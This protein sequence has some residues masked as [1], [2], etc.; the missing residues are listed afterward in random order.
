MKMDDIKLISLNVRGL[1]NREKRMSIYHYMRNKRADIIYLQETHSTERTYFTWKTEWNSDMICAQGTRGVAILFSKKINCTKE[2]IY[3]HPYGRLL[4]VKFTIGEKC[5]LLANVYNYNIDDTEVFVTL[6]DQ[7]M[8][9]KDVDYF[10]LAGDFNLALDPTV[11]RY[12]GG[13]LNIHTT[14]YL[15]QLMEDFELID[16]WRNRHPNDV[17][18]SWERS[19]PKYTASRLDYI[20]CSETFNNIVHNVEYKHAIR[21]DHKAIVLNLQINQ[22]KRGSGLW[23][24][25]NMMLNDPQFRIFIKQ[26][27]SKA[28][29]KYQYCSPVDKWELIKVCIITSAQKYAKNKA[30]DKQANYNNNLNKLEQIDRQLLL[31][32]ED[33]A[34]HKLKVSIQCQIDDYF[35]EKAMSAAFRSK[36]RWND[37][38]EKS[39]KYF[40]SLE[41]SNYNRKTMSSL[42]RPD[43]SI[44]NNQR[45]ILTAQADF[46]AKLYT[47][48]PSVKFRLVNDTD[49]KISLEMRNKLDEAISLHELSLA[50]KS[51]KKDKVPGCDGLSID[52]YEVIWEDIKDV[53]YNMTQYAM[54]HESMPP[55]SMKGV[56]SLLPKKGK[57]PLLI[58][59][60]RPLTLLNNDFKI[61]SKVLADRIRNVLPTIIL[62]DQTGFMKNRQISA[63][64]RKTMDIIHNLELREKGGNVIS[65][66]YV[67]CFDKIEINS[68]L[69]ALRYFG[70]G[71][72]YIKMVEILQRKFSTCVIN[73]GYTSDWF[74]V[75]RSTHQG[76]PLATYLFSA[77]GET[78][79]HVIKQNLDIQPI[80]MYDIPQVL[81]QFAD[82]TQLFQENAHTSLDATANSMELVQKNLGLEVSYDK[83]RI[84]CINSELLLEC[85]TQW[86]W[87]LD[88]P[89][90]LGVDSSPISNQLFDILDKATDIFKSWRNRCLTLLGKIVI[91]NTLIASLYVYVLQVVE[92][93]PEM[94]YEMYDNIVVQYLW[95]NKRPKIR[96][97]TLK[98]A[99]M[100]GGQKLCDLQLK[101]VSLKLNW[102]F[103]TENHV[104]LM[105]SNLIPNCLVRCILEMSI[106]SSTCCTFY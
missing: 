54:T 82:D 95:S 66:D 77:C 63:T 80:Y 30:A 55:S 39:T 60:W 12:G 49:I 84:H 24:F 65:L 56:I 7:V 72:N 50:V 52:L 73:N 94:L 1:G 92:D 13:Q 90:L 71:E 26:C 51:M 9:V 41:K 22:Q 53:F 5:F 86:K 57:N 2:L 33:T 106:I 102:I 93:P 98:S 61:I 18:Y 15:R 45:E 59:N 29:I 6:K 25:N 36:C 27:I 14:Q 101:M 58:Q 103:R 88:Y 28:K 96:L 85:N 19:A 105:M 67:K 62:D 23:K 83:S 20:L 43:N 48:D 44:T 3:T 32:P 42:Q 74:P 40:Y 10:I 79:A 89:V 16:M 75:T 38:G 37:E 46:Y 81:S 4:I 31:T 78:M 11:D 76:D 47:S 97:E 70:F 99:K 21:T 87:D 91:V 100:Q 17:Q 8:K 104:K 35:S 69:G 68:I 34:L 64:I